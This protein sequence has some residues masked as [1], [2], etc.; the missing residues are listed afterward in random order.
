[1]YIQMDGNH[2]IHEHEE[3]L[4]ILKALSRT[5]FM[6]WVS[7]RIERFYH[8]K[9]WRTVLPTFE[10]INKYQTETFASLD[11]LYISH[12][13]RNYYYYSLEIMLH[14]NYSN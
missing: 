5:F 13:S 1:M 14:T 12:T 4:Y 10:V 11:N 2:E 6:V 3:F 8:F 9:I 7:N